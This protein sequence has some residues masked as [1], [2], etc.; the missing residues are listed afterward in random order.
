MDRGSLP[1]PWGVQRW[2][3]AERNVEKE[4]IEGAR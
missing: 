3:P 1:S 2:N 4:V